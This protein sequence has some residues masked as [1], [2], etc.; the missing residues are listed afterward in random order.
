[1]QDYAWLTQHTPDTVQRMVLCT[2]W[3]HHFR[4]GRTTCSPWTR[5]PQTYGP[6]TSCPPS[7]RVVL[8][9][10]V[11]G[12]PPNAKYQRHLSSDGKLGMQPG[13][14]AGFIQ[15]SS[16]STLKQR[17]ACILLL[18]SNRSPM[19]ELVLC[20]QTL[21]KKSRD[22]SLQYVI[23]T[24]CNVVVLRRIILHCNIKDGVVY[25]TRQQWLVAKWLGLGVYS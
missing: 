4:C 3:V 21:T 8:G 14:N 2:N 19:P 10:K 25:R 20:S 15:Q 11:P 5:C 7:G 13:N 16:M 17:M 22:R 23:F 6:R 1:M 24:S 12:R 9:P 18:T